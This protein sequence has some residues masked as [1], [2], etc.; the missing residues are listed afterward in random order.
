[1]LIDIVSDTICPW[2]YI[3]KKRF[4]RAVAESG[5]DDIMVAWRPFQLNPDMPPAGMGRDAYLRLKFGGSDRARNI[6][7]TIAENGREEGIDFQ[8][9]RIARTPNTVRSHRLIHWSG[10]LGFQDQ[11]VD[12]LFKAY[13]EEGRD[14]GDNEALIDA[15]VRAG[16]DR[17]DTR[18][19]LESDE[20]A[21]EVV[22][23]DGHARRMGIAGV[24]CFVVDRKYAVSGAQP[25]EA[26]LEVFNLAAR[27]AAQAATSPAAE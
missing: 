5:R 19:F 22:A 20:L 26:F 27:D 24:P 14:I 13:F 16:L 15:A 23:A 10:P 17:R 18:A 2:C 12:S 9:D 6:Y 3:G 21:P 7:R 25:T 4:E 11:V 8:F 1:M